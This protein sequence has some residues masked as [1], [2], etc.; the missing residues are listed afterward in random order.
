MDLI[1]YQVLLPNNFWDLAKRNE[2]LNMMIDT[3]VLVT[4]IT[5]FNELSILGKRILQFVFGG[6]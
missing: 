6:K 3:L 5:R 4:R 2:E 1:E